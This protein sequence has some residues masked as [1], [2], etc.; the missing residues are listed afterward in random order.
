MGPAVDYAGR[1][2]L[3]HIRYFLAVA[4][5]KN[6]SRAADELHIVQPALS[7]QIKKLEQELELPLFFRESSGI[8]LTPAGEAFLPRA[9][10]I[11]SEVDDAVS[12]LRRLRPAGAGGQVAFGLMRTLNPWPMDVPAL[13]GAF[14][15]SHPQVQ[16]VVREGTAEELVALLRQGELNAAV[17]D[18]ALLPALAPLRVQVLGTE[19]M[20]VIV[21]ESHRLAARTSVNLA[22]LAGEPFLRLASGSATRLEAIVKACRTAGHEPRF[23]LSPASVSMARSLV[24]SGVGIYI[25]SRWA[26]E[27]PGPPVKIL[28][29]EGAPLATQLAVVWRGDIDAPATELLRLVRASLR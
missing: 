10:R 9:Q 2:E 28:A 4:R 20:V 19:P 29:L 17:M 16:V 24:S 14:N 3:R 11:L 21:G 27:A 18:V 6:F 22:D 13:L 12:E 26:A 1:M 23:S 25:T 7:Q 8:S 5:H 15:H